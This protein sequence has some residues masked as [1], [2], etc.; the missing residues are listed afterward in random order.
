MLTTALGSCTSSGEEE[1]RPIGRVLRGVS[2]KGEEG[3]AP[4]REEEGWEE[5]WEEDGEEGGVERKGG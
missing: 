1:P 2:V 5:E 4:T 3:A